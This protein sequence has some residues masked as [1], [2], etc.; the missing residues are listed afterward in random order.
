MWQ[1]RESLEGYLNEKIHEA[2]LFQ[3]VK[4]SGQSK[5]EEAAQKLETHN[6]L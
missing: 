4:Y 5:L 6:S 1:M 2:S 3:K